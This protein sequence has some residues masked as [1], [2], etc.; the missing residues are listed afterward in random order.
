MSSDDISP[1][2]RDMLKRA[3][4]LSCLEDSSSSSTS[5]IE[6]DYVSNVEKGMILHASRNSKESCKDDGNK[7]SRMQ[8]HYPFGGA[9]HDVLSPSAVSDKP[10]IH[11]GQGQ[12]EGG[13]GVRRT[14]LL[15]EIWGDVSAHGSWTDG[16]TAI[17]DI[18]VTDTECPS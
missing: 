6:R 13:A 7:R 4:K 14:E 8:L 3:L 9:H 18:Q 5:V 2:E 16:T 17:F 15:P 10:L 12:Q 1:V 11:N